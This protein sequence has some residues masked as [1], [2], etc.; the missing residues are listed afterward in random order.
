MMALKMATVY[1]VVAV[2]FACPFPCLAH[3]AASGVVC[4]AGD[5]GTT[6][7]CPC[8]RPDGGDEPGSDPGSG[9]CLCHGAVMDPAAAL[10]SPDAGL[11]S[12]LPLDRLLLGG[13]SFPIQDRTLAWRASGHFPSADSGRQVR[14]LIESLLL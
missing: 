3:V 7:G 1:L 10:P 11:V 2:L 13:E 14:V 9:T 8:P 6:D 5:C 12:V 4:A